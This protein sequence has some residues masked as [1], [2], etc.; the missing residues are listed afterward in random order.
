MRL[1]KTDDELKNRMNFWLIQKEF[2]KIKASQEEHNLLKEEYNVLL[3][4]S[5]ELQKFKQMV[6]IG[7]NTELPAGQLPPHI[8]AEI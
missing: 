1:G 5:Q 8:V 2:E 4:K 7:C 3:D 6:N